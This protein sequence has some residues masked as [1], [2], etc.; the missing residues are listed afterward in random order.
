MVGGGLA[1]YSYGLGWGRLGELECGV[2]VGSTLDLKSF[3]GGF[4]LEIMLEFASEVNG[5]PIFCFGCW[6]CAAFAASRWACACFL[7]C[8]T[9]MAFFCISCFF[10]PTFVAALSVP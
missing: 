9:R 1:G 5:H 3:G 4:E 2:D 7:S 10:K 8:R 6:C